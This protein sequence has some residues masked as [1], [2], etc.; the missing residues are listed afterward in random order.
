MTKRALSRE[1]LEELG[2][3]EAEINIAFKLQHQEKVRK[4]R[5]IVL[6]TT[7]EAEEFSKNTGKEF[8]RATEWKDKR[9]R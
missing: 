3:G 7:K 2:L 5:Y 6:L 8:V 1:E 9:K 4:Y